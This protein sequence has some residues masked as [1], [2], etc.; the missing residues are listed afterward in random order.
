MS[1]KVVIPTP[2]RKHTG[3]AEVV[4]VEA[5]TLKEVIDRLESKF[6]G[7][8]NSVCDDSGGLRRFINVYLDGE[9]VRFLE[10]LS[11]PAKDGSE[12]AIVPAISC[13]AR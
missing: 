7:I 13:G 5:G 1:L 12:I 11:T 4:E 6:P 9:D 10:N 3:G 8:R 2:L